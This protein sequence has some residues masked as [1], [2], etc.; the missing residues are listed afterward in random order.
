MFFLRPDRIGIWKCCNKRRFNLQDKKKTFYTQAFDSI[1]EYLSRDGF[2]RFVTWFVLWITWHNVSLD[3][4]FGALQSMSMAS[5]NLLLNLSSSLVR[6]EEED[7]VW[8]DFRWS[9]TA[10]V[11][12]LESHSKRSSCLPKVEILTAFALNF[13]HHSTFL[14]PGCQIFGVDQM[15]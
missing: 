3:R 14:F 5:L 13:V 9:P 7:K 15:Q 11:D 1:A 8:P 10:V 12:A 4:D 2:G 6:I